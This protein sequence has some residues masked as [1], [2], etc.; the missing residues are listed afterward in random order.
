MNIVQVNQGS[1]MWLVERAGKATASRA[2]DIMSFLS[3]K[4]KNGELGESSA[5]RR[6]YLIEV[7][8]SRITG[9]ATE[10]YVSDAMIHGSEQEQ[11]ARAAYEMAS[12]N[13]VDQVGIVLHSTIENFGASPDGLIGSDGLWEGKCPTTPKHIGWW[14]ADEVPDEHIPQMDA[15]M[16]CTGRLWC[17]FTSFDPRIPDKELRYFTKRLYR[18]EERIAGLEKHVVRFLQEVDERVAKLRSR[19]SRPTLNQQLRDSLDDPSLLIT[20]LDLPDWYREMSAQKE[21]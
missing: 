11:F 1:E 4:S 15:Q 3:R 10:H 16:S 6:N 20:E 2:A 21:K 5:A 8:C 12:G 7:V 14:E 9:M 19:M 17:D 13:E 18:S